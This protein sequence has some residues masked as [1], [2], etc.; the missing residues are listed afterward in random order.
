METDEEEKKKNF[1]DDY[2]G[3]SDSSGP[4]S[5]TPQGR[6]SK[7]RAELMVSG[8]VPEF[9][10]TVLVGRAVE[11]DN[12]FRFMLS[13]HYYVSKTSNVVYAGNTAQEAWE[14]EST[15][16]NAAGPGRNSE[17]Y[18]FAPRGMPMN[19]L[20][21]DQLRSLMRNRKKRESD[22]G[23]AY[24]LLRE[25]YDIARSVVPQHRD[26][27][28]QFILDPRNNYEP[29][30]VPGVSSRWLTQANITRPPSG[31]VD[32]RVPGGQ[33]GGSGMPVPALVDALN[34]D[35]TG[36]YIMLHGHPGCSNHFAG[37]IIDYA[38]CVERRSAFGYGLSRLL[39]PISKSIAFRRH[40]A[41]I[42][43][44]PNYYQEA[45]AR[46]NR[47]HPTKNFVPQPGPHFSLRRLR[48]TP[49][50]ASNLTTQDVLNVLFDNGV[51]MEWI[52]HSYPYGVA[53]IDHCLASSLQVDMFRNVDNERLARLARY[54]TPAAI[55][56]WGGWRHPSPNEIEQLHV[57]PR[58]V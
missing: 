3:G 12:T 8:P 4:D 24:L 56:G 40:F 33:R 27:A 23:E 37:V 21:V 17:V 47:A 53:F 38:F 48:M 15:T 14:Y 28:M 5:D 54:G 36:L 52:N 9:W 29:D 20:E 31:N 30:Y 16:G 39:A 43:A 25:F 35:L 58:G 26:R 34:V 49:N 1:L 7:R 32:P 57:N 19:P 45:I 6:E 46:Y 13:R 11:R 2:L 42:V 41:C 51:P 50:A 55:P 18:V 10:G 22:R 44:L